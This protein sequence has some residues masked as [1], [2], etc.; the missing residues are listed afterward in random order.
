M[1]S[2]AHA[3]AIASSIGVVGLMSYHV[4]TG[5]NTGNSGALPAGIAST[6][7]PAD[8][9]ANNPNSIKSN[10]VV[11]RSVPSGNPELGEI[12][13]AH[14]FEKA[15]D[16]EPSSGWC[17]VEVFSPSEDPLRKRISLRSFEGEMTYDDPLA[18][19]GFS[20]LG[21][22]RATLDQVRSQCPWSGR[23]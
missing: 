3:I 7:T 13:A 11:F 20:R 10:V 9:D 12:I 4:F 2:V 17:Y 15:T 22:D 5:A 6:M 19:Q 16:E 18:L 21:L 8:E 1:I 14:E 23:Q